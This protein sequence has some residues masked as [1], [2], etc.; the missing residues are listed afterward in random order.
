MGNFPWIFAKQGKDAGKTENLISKSILS[1]FQPLS[2][3]ERKLAVGGGRE[4]G[5]RRE[6]G[7][8][9]REK[10][11]FCPWVSLEAELSRRNLGLDHIRRTLLASGAQSSLQ[12]TQGS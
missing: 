2:K 4:K 7:T 5:A 6:G 11:F 8:R 9:K 12:E 10:P 3:K 1:L